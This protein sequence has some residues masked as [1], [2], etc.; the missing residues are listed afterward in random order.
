[1][2]TTEAIWQI[3]RCCAIIVSNIGHGINNFV[4]RRSWFA[5]VIVIL[6]CTVM[7]VVNIMSARA[8]RDS[9][10][11]KQYQLQQQIEQLT[12]TLEARKEVRQ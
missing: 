11:K 6:F 5:I 12:Y 8:E 4:T 10:L 3:L 1:M 9:A 2:K 7:S